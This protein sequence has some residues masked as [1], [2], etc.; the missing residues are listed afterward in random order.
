MDRILRD[1][2]ERALAVDGGTHTLEDLIKGVERGLFQVWHGVHSI[3]VTQIMQ[4]PQRR[5]LVVFIAAGLL[6]EIQELEPIILEWG[7]QQGCKRAVFAGRKGWARSF[8]TRDSGW[9]ETLVVIEKELTHGER[10]GG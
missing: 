8:L 7:A 9:R 2:L 5:D 10:K 3:V 6:E 4:T 1:K